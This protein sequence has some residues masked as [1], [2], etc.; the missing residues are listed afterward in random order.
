MYPAD[1]RYTKDHEWIKVDGSVG[2]IGI[3]DYAQHE[4]GDVVFVELPKIGARVK[5]GESFGSVESVKAV[6][7][8]FSP[9][10]GEIAEINSALVNEPEKINQDPHGGAWLI[11]IKLDDPK[12]TASLM[13]AQAYQTYV[14]EKAQEQSA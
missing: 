3:T 6:S 5:P 13:D 9:V 10:S 2:T 11:R 1:Y 12:E 14:D 4:L 7:D 8:I